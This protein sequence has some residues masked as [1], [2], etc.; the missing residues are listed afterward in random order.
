MLLIDSTIERAVLMP[1]MLP[2]LLCESGVIK[3]EEEI[4]E[5][6]L[7]ISPIKLQEVIQ[8]IQNAENQLI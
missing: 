1:D 3:E 6:L 2:H 7:K 5:Y 8:E 4:E